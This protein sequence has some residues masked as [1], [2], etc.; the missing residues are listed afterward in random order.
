MTDNASDMS[1]TFEVVTKKNMEELIRINS[2]VLPIT[3]SSNTIYQ[4]MVN[5]GM[6]YLAGHQVGS[7]N[8]H[9]T[10]GGGQIEYIGGIGCR[11]ETIKWNTVNSPE[12]S[13]PQVPFPT[14]PT[15]QKPH[16]RLYV[17]T[18]A[19]L[20]PYRS[21]G[22]GRQLMHRM[23]SDAREMERTEDLC[24][25]QVYLHVQTSNEEAIRFYERF[26][27]EKIK[28]L[29]QF[30]KRIENPDCYLMV[31]DVRKHGWMCE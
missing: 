30:Y 1:I 7:N 16:L 9:V 22:I 29:K 2:A 28:V 6:S 26:G 8:K 24:I 31:L 20:A 14:E 23:M 15:D 4:Q 18:L 21:Q 19:V 11:L 10:T 3:Y 5:V 13:L 27:F 25:D 12:N 17:M